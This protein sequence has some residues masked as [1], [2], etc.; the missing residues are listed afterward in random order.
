MQP[1]SASCLV[2]PYAPTGAIDSTGRITLQALAVTH[3][4]QETAVHVQ[5]RWPLDVTFNL[6]GFPLHIN[7][8][9]LEDDS[10]E[11]PCKLLFTNSD[12]H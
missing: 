1:G 7:A 3:A 4:E 6:G 5:A 9:C 12:I 2:Q 11:L 10:E 8:L